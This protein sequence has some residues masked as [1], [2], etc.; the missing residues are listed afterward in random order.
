MGVVWGG[1]SI[2]F[3]LPGC[4]SEAPTLQ[5]PHSRRSCVAGF[6][7]YLF[8]CRF[9]TAVTLSAIWSM[10]LSSRGFPNAFR[11]CL[12][13]LGVGRLLQFSAAGNACDWSFGFRR[14]R[15]RHD[16]VCLEQ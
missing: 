10:E 13:E 16:A 9:R 15:T 3:E 2:V 5:G 7:G 8:E 4:L 6:P 11:P 1:E 14:H 12:T